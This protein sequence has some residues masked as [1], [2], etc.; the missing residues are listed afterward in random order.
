LCIAGTIDGLLRSR[1]QKTWLAA[2]LVALAG[3]YQAN[4]GLAYKQEWTHL[5]AFAWQITWRAPSLQPGA[6]LLTEKSGFAYHEDDSLAALV[7]WIYAPEWQGGRMPY[8][9]FGVSERLNKGLPAL[10]P[11]LPVVKEVRAATFE[12]STSRALV[13]HYDPPGCL[14]ILDPESENWQA[15]Y[16]DMLLRAVPLSNLALIP[17]DSTNQANP[18][19]GVFGE[20]PKHRWCYYFEKADLSR[21]FGEW[22]KIMQLGNEAFRQGYYP[23]TAVEFLPFIEGYGRLRY[24]DDAYQVSQKA[25]QLDASIQPALCSLWQRLSSDLSS[26]AALERNLARLRAEPGCRL[27]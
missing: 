2:G 22:D 18:P 25:Y 23:E 16:P 1:A 5:S 3:A 20:E 12:G 19:I 10:K 26:D 14:H 27:P 9:V 17:I 4:L 21:Q 7:N 15:N 6:L 8:M 13:F 11:G 24:W